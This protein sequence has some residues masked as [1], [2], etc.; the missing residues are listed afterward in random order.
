MRRL[1]KKPSSPYNK[2]GSITDAS[3]FLQAGMH[4][5]PSINPQVKIVGCSFL[6]SYERRRGSLYIYLIQPFVES[7]HLGLGLGHKLRKLNTVN[8]DF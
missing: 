8:G 1:W 7:V 4:T 3:G 6:P 2:G 5:A